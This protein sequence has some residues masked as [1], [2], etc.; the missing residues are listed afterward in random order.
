MKP[1]REKAL[2]AAFAR[3]RDVAALAQIES[4][5]REAPHF[6]GITF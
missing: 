1:L 5:S 2:S 4:S 3:A 6:S